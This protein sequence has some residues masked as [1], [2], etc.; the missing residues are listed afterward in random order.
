ME[1]LQ[2]G[3]LKFCDEFA[4]NP[5]GDFLTPKISWELTFYYVAKKL[6]CKLFFSSHFSSV[7]SSKHDKLVWSLNFYVIEMTSKFAGDCDD[8]VIDSIISANNTLK[9]TSD[10]K[11]FHLILNVS[12]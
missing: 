4:S 7:I 1:S 10:F 12:I 3:K 9:R 5:F 11:L 8:L 2:K 6:Y